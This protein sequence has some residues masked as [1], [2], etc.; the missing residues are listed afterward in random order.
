MFIIVEPLIFHAFRGGQDTS[1]FLSLCTLS[2]LY[3]PPLKVVYLCPSML[4]LSACS[5]C[6]LSVVLHI[7]T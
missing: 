6:Y 7:L 1:V 3:I 5:H 4:K 2:G